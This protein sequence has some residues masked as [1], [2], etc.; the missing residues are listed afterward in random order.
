[1]STFDDT[2]LSMDRFS[3]IQEKMIA[4]FKAAFGDTI[5]TSAD[6]VFGQIIN[7][8]SSAIADQNELIE[9]IASAFNPQSASGVF[10]SNLV[11]MNGIQRKEAEKSTVALLVTANAAGCTIPAGS[12]VSDPSVPD[13]KVETDAVKVL[14]PSASDTISATALET[15]PLVFPAN[16][17]TKIETPVYGWESVNNPADGSDGETEETDTELRLRR[18]RAAETNVSTDI[19]AIYTDLFN[20]DQVE[21]LIV[22]QNSD[23]ITD[24]NGVPRQHVWAVVRGGSDLDIATALFN[25]VSAGIGTF[26]TT[27]QAVIDPITSQSHDMNFTRPTEKAVYVE[28]LTNSDPNVYPADGDDQIKQSIVDY[29]E[30]NDFTIDERVIEKIKIGDNVIHSRMFTPVNVIAGHNVQSIKI[31]F[32]SPPTLELDLVLAADEIAGFDIADITVVSTPVS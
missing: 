27:T 25:A 26:G 18:L 2:G 1:M 9:G 14:A 31:G 11:L 7:I 10:L 22:Y 17:L 29:F 23:Q 30:G 19:G 12:I 21:D 6:S 13:N 20:I 32:S 24:A 4:D 8:L 5:K 16:S 15:G 28:V 3:E